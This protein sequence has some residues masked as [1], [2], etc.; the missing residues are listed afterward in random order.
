[1]LA[2]RTENGMYIMFWYS[3]EKQ[4]ANLCQKKKQVGLW[5][6]IFMSE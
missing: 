5:I 4:F 1:M 2:S 3:K 6:D